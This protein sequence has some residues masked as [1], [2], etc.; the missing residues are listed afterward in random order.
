[1]EFSYKLKDFFKVKNNFILFYLDFFTF[2]PTSAISTAQVESPRNEEEET[3]QDLPE[4][5]VQEEP[6]NPDQEPVN[7]EENPE[8]PASEEIEEIQAE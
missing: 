1:M 6:E 2:R 4:E 5:E 8:E 7:S 3:V